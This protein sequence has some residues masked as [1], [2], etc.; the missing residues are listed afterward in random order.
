MAPQ[1][2]ALHIINRIVKNGG[3]TYTELESRA[4]EKKIALELFEAAMTIV[5]KSK[6]I[7]S[8][9][10]VKG[11]IRYSVA[12]AKAPTGPLSHIKWWNDHY[13]RPP[14]DWVQPFPE[15]N[16]DH[17][18]LK[19]AQFLEYKAKLKGMAFIPRKKKYEHT[20]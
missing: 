18:F 12:V 17:L 14:A 7:R 20:L 6:T 13:P 4:V 15:I 11:E 19:P 2:L 3:M 9:T 16:F 10:T 1:S 5:H 8:S